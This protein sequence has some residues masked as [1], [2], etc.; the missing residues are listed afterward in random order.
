MQGVK[1]GLEQV[2]VSL[3]TLDSNPDR[4]GQASLQRLGNL[5]FCLQDPSAGKPIPIRPLWPGDGRG[6][7]VKCIRI[8]RETGI[9]Q[10]IP[11]YN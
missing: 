10:Q 6:F 7:G 5:S 9:P 4:D 3:A 2:Q 1:L 8:S 11:A